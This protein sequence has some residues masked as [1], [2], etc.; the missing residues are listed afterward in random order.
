MATCSSDARRSLF[1]VSHLLDCIVRPSR[2]DKIMTIAKYILSTGV[3]NT[4]ELLA[5]RREDLAGYHTFIQWAKEQA[6]HNGVAIEE[7]EKK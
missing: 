6:A 2:R 7:S 5:L 3:C 4:S 1:P